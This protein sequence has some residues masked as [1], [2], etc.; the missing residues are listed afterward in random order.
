MDL[1]LVF[2]ICILLLLIGMVFFL[3]IKIKAIEELSNGVVDILT[4]TLEYYYDTK[5]MQPCMVNN[6][7]DIV[8]NPEKT[9]DVSNK[10]GFITIW[11]E[12]ASCDT[13]IKDVKEADVLSEKIIKVV[14]KHLKERD[15]GV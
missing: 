13:P 14:E 6:G 11:F 4:R 5:E 1:I 9:E 2:F 10:K 15:L 8:Y 12:G 7:I 3:F